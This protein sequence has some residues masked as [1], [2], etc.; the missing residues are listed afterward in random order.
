MSVNFGTG[1]LIATP[2]AGD[3]NANPTPMQFGV[4]Q[5]VSIDFSGDIKELFGQYQFA[6]YSARGKVKISWKAKAA[7]LVGKQVNDLFFSET[8]ASTMVNVAVDEA[9]TIPS[10]PFNVTVVYST[11]SVSDV[12]VYFFTAS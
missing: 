12:V 6:A 5:D 2:N 4:L 3:I 10:T 1:T 11:T 8:L 9:G 7:R